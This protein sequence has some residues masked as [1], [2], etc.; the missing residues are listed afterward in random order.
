MIDR[1]APRKRWNLKRGTALL[2]LVAATLGARNNPKENSM[3]FV[4]NGEPLDTRVMGPDWKTEN[5]TLACQGQNSINHRILAGKTLGKGDF[6]IH[7][8]LAIQGLRK[9]AAAFVLGDKTF[10][11]FDGS[12]GSVFITGPLFGNARGDKIGNPDKFM[13]E[14]HAFTFECTRSGNTVTICIDGRT[15]YEQTPFTTDAIGTFGF[16]PVRSTIRLSD[17][18]ATGNLLEYTPPTVFVKKQ[19]VL[20]PKAD[21]LDALMMGPY[22]RL[23]DGAILAVDKNDACRSETNGKTWSRHPIFA[24]PATFSIRP[25]RALLQTQK[26][27]VL[28]VFL[29]DAEKIYKWD[30]KRNM[31]LPGMR[32]PTYCVRSEDNGKTWHPPQRLYDGWCGAIRDIIQTTQGTIVIPGQELLMDKG[33]HAT[34]PYASSDDGKTWTYADVLDIP[35]QGDHAGAVEGTLEEL[36]DGRI[37]LL[38]RSSHGYFYESFADGAALNWTDIKPSPIAA[39]GAPGLLARLSDQSLVLVWNRR[40]LHGTET[41]QHRT[42]LSVAFSTD[43]GTTWSTPVVLATNPD[44]NVNNANRIAYPYVFEAQP[45]YLWI[46]SM[47]GSLR[48]GIRVNDFR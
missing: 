37:W 42:E 33:R 6:R 30:R 23:D 31:P 14:G 11:G 20:H 47:Q 32:L 18:T 12:H 36:N 15:V 21:R 24:A 5:G 13:T 1:K 40:C 45:G 39:S 25:E 19:P 48:T 10:F 7:A 22:I 29:N 9:S 34:R 46:T 41:K 2:L 4:K 16:T 8:K 38:M 26:G 44:G 3:T 28:L 43:D 27:T 17:F 35:G